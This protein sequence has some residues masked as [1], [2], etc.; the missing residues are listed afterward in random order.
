[1]FFYI[2]KMLES[3]RVK[4]QSIKYVRGY[5]MSILHQL[6]NK[7]RQCGKEIHVY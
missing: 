3:Y 2:E 4:E 7:I 1:M 6:V 5:L